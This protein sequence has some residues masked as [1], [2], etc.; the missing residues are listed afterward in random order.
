M[1]YL[2][3]FYHR[4]ISACRV[5]ILPFVFILT[6]NCTILYCSTDADSLLIISINV[7]DDNLYF[8][9]KDMFII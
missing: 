5:F 9:G 2:R 1:W 3:F 6:F 4:S 7:V 8:C